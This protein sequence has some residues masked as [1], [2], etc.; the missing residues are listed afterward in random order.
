MLTELWFLRSVAKRMEK[1]ENECKLLRERIRM[2]TCPHCEEAI[3]VN[4][5]GT[6]CDGCQRIVCELCGD[7]MREINE[8]ME[9]YCVICQTNQCHHDNCTTVPTNECECCSQTFCAN[10][11]I[12]A[13]CVCGIIKY[14][15]SCRSQMI[16]YMNLHDD[17][18]SGCGEFSCRW[19]GYIEC[20]CV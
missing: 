3:N 8:A 20:S 19:H 7:A 1:A 4:H 15:S 6:E 18:C 2:M 9:L 13:R 11:T 10:H 16:D 17:R 12:D 14:C 5:G